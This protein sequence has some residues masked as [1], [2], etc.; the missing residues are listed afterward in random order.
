MR[1]ASVEVRSS[2]VFDAA[3]YPQMFGGHGPLRP[4]L[5]SGKRTSPRRRD[6]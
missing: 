5:D 2:G 3:Q 6:S 4:R 1:C